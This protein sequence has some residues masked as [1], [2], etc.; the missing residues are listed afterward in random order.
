MSRLLRRLPYYWVESAANFA[1]GMLPFV[2]CLAVST[3][4]AVLIVRTCLK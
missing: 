3:S 2:L 1:R 4:G